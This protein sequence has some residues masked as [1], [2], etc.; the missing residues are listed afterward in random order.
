MSSEEETIPCEGTTIPFY[1]RPGVQNDIIPAGE[2]VPFGMEIV[3]HPNL[4]IGGA[5]GAWGN[6]Y[7]NETLPSFI[8]KRMGAPLKDE[9]RLQLSTLGF[10]VRH[11]IGDLSEEEHLQVEVEVGARFLRAAADA[12]GWDP[13]E[14]DAVLIG[15]SG[16][17]SDD[18]TVKIAQEAG[19]PESA[20]KVSMHK[21]CDSSMGAL[22]LVMNPDLEI[23]KR[24]GYN[25]AEELHGKKVL[26]GGIEGLSRFMG[27]SRDTTALQLFGNGAGVIGVIPGETM[28][29]LIGK[30][31][32]VFDEAGVLAVRM[33]Y[34]HSRRAI[35][36][37]MLETS[38]AGDNHY[39]VAG[40]MHEPLSGMPV[41]MAGPMGMVKLFVRNGVDVV[42][43]VY[44]A[45][46]ELM[47]DLGKNSEALVT[48]V[49]H[50]ANLK[51]NRLKEKHLQKLGINLSMP[52]V[53]SEFGNV[54]AASNMIA[55]LRQLPSFHPGDHILFDGFGAG[56]YYDVLAVSLGG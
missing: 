55:F 56:T 44:S 42:Q 33:Y 15:M 31:R 41:E 52:W 36:G 8:E 49:V 54:S 24:L 29:F 14:V 53:L 35:D 9:D 12:N 39:R 13:S 51:I 3:T 7:D 4:G 47:N 28:R 48:A 37:S 11:H 17:V 22:N 50:H 45:Y 19:I 5:Y 34:P 32:E 18:Y 16:P 26:V 1:Q 10:D 30:S 46:Q 2:G 38:R 40:M 23:H 6:T 27:R 21:A 20:L 43:D 25:L